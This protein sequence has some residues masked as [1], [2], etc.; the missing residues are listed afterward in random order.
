MKKAEIITLKQ[1]AAEKGYAEASAR[2]LIRRG[3][4]PQAQKKGRDWLIPANIEWPADR[5]YKKK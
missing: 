5:R 4:L 3:K 2:N 1:W